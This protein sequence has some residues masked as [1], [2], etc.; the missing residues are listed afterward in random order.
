M[1]ARLFIEFYSGRGLAGSSFGGG[2]T[3]TGGR[4]WFGWCLYLFDLLEDAGMQVL[5][6]VFVFQR[7]LRGFL[8]AGHGGIEV[9]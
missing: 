1:L 5:V 2:G 9:L 3:A 7:I 8:R 4:G 6:H